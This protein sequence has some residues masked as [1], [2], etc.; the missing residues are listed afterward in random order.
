[1][2][3]RFEAA[4]PPQNA[5]RGDAELFFSRELSWLAFN[6]RVLEEALD[7]KNP[8]L[9]RLK[10]VS[11][12]GTNLDEF[13]MIRVAAIKQQ[14]AAGVTTRSDDG[15]L[16]AEHFQAISDYIRETL[17]QQMKV[18]RDEI[19][20]AIAEKGVRILSVTDLDE[21]RARTVEHSALGWPVCIFSSAS[22]HSTSAPPQAGHQSA[23]VSFAS[24][25]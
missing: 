9:E 5:E 6:D 21:E 24:S 19:L 3:Q 10:F 4:I 15:R 23:T 16:P 20:P 2:L 14:I 22:S 7:P 17:P 18:L 11:I 1:M 25:A 12:F 13:F 8:L